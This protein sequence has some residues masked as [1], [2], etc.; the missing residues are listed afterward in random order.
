MY[1]SLLP[2]VDTRRMTFDAVRLSTDSRG[3]QHQRMHVCDE[4]ICINTCIPVQ[5]DLVRNLHPRAELVRKSPPLPPSIPVRF[6][7][8]VQSNQSFFR[9]R[10]DFLPVLMQYTLATP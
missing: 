6:P 2:R 4:Y 3:R 9:V 1:R 10:L 8:I 5:L 7:G